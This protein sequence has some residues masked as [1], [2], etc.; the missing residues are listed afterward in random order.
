MYLLNNSNIL[1]AEFHVAA[2][3]EP[4]RLLPEAHTERILVHTCVGFLFFAF[5]TYV[6]GVR[7]CLCCLVFSS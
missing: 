3:S 2:F 1:G 6:K 5:A 7:L 4:S